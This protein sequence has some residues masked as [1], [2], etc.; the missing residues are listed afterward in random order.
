MTNK[1]FFCILTMIFSFCAAMP[2]FAQVNPQNLSNVRVDE[3]SDDQVRAFMRQVEAIGLGEAQL[4][5]V[6]QARGMR[7][8]E[9]RKLRERVNKLKAEEKPSNDPNSPLPRNTGRELNYDADTI[10]VQRDPETEAERA[11]QELRSKIFGADLFRNSNLTFEPNLNMATPQNYV[12][13]P[14]DELLIDLYGNSEASYNLKVS[15]EGNINIEYVG[16]VPVSGLTIEAATARIR[17]RMSTV[18]GG[19]S[20]GS[21][22]LN[23]AIGN[24]RSIKV[25]LTGEVQKPGTY[26]LPSLAT[27]FNALYSSG[28]PTENGSFRAIEVIRGGRIVSRLDIYEFLLNGTMSDNLRLQDQDVIRIPVYK[29]AFC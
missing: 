24:I 29:T 28:G 26:T 18:Y 4:E 20:N 5:Q 7:P 6:A 23:V 21:T 16:V 27:V 10:S 3:L 2:A 17:S 13:G 9:I 25:I 11:L 14:A 19:L 1:K 22:R 8:E 15:P 12:I